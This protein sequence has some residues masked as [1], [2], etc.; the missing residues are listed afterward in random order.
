MFSSSPGVR[1]PIAAL[2]RHRLGENP[3]TAARDPLSI[4]PRNEERSRGGHPRYPDATTW[5]APN[6]FPPFYDGNSL[7]PLEAAR[8]DRSTVFWLMPPSCGRIGQP[9]VPQPPAFPGAEPGWALLRLLSARRCQG[10]EAAARSGSSVPFDA[11]R[12]GAR[13]GWLVPPL[14][15]RLT[16][17]LS[18]Y[19]GIVYVAIT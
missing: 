5:V 10:C 14:C 3:R 8:N 16:F 19:E 17:R 18:A 12:A 2:D 15:T 1:L 11:P 4:I 7:C 6:P 9:T 13:C